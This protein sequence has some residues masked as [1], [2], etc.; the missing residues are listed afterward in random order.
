[1]VATI[2]EQPMLITRTATTLIPGRATTTGFTRCGDPHFQN[3]DYQVKVN[4]YHS[5]K[6]IEKPVGQRVY[7]TQNDCQ[8]GRDIL[9][10]DK[11]QGR[12]NY[13]KCEHCAKKE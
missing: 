13:R 5:A 10:K 2:P 9:P 11:V 3:G 6:E 8:S 12:S 4:P 1:M 7:H